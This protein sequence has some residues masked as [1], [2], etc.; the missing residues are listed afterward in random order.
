MLISF[1]IKNFKSIGEKQTFSMV[2]ANKQSTENVCFESGNSL[3]PRAL[4]SACIFGPNG[5]GKTSFVKAMDAFRDFVLDSAK[6]QK[7]EK[8][9]WVKP[10]ML[11]TELRNQP[12]EFEATFVHDGALYQYGFAVD[13]ERVWREWLLTRSNTKGAKPL[14][15]FQREFDGDK[16]SW[17]I[18]DAHVK[19]QKEAWKQQTKANSLFLSEALRGNAE[20]LSLVKPFEWIQK[21]LRIIS[22]SERIGF[23]FSASQYAS[24]K[25]RN[26]IL[27]FLDSTDSRIK[28]IEVKE[29]TID[30][31]KFILEEIPKEILEELKN[32]KIKMFDLS[33][34]HL[35][36]LGN[37]IK[38]D[39]E[40]MSDGIKTLFGLAG[41]WLDVLENGY[42]LIVDELHNSLHPH[43]LQF[44]VALFYDE[45]LNKKNAQLIFTSHETSIMRKGVLHRDQIWL[46]CR[47][48]QDQSE[49]YSLAEFKNEKSVANFQAAYLNGRYGALPKIKGSV[50]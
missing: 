42:T 46:I 24:G 14:T 21:F 2:A 29:K 34:I 50:A 4:K 7:N 26:E 16:Y 37:A 49:M 38:F 6:S 18:N 27:R 13:Q 11:N 17:Q 20:S 40:E 12:S 15:V 22:S 31:P 32:E 1:S 19:G 41:P 43:A 23:G 36:D 3:A 9:D 48:D 5:A 30:V 8:I 47:D 39:R 25:Y 35:D 45:R 44:L 28:D 33:F 10:F